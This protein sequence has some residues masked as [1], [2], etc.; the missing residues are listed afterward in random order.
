MSISGPRPSESV[1]PA[2]Q[3]MAAVHDHITPPRA[4]PPKGRA[5]TSTVESRR[6]LEMLQGI[7]G[8]TSI[9]A[10]IRRDLPRDLA[11]GA[12]F[13]LGAFGVLVGGVGAL[14]MK[15]AS[16]AAGAAAGFVGTILG[17]IGNKIFGKPQSTE[18]AMKEAGA[19]LPVRAA[20]VAFAGLPSL[21]DGAISKL[22]L[23][24]VEALRSSG[25]VSRENGALQSAE[26]FFNAQLVTLADA[27]KAAADIEGVGKKIGTDLETAAKKL[28]ERWERGSGQAGEEPEPIPTPKSVPVPLLSANFERAEAEDGAGRAAER[29]ESVSTP[30]RASKPPL[31]FPLY[32]DL[33]RRWDSILKDNAKIPLAEWQKDAE[34]IHGTPSVIALGRRNLQQAV[35]DA[36]TDRHIKS[37]DDPVRHHPVFIRQEYSQQQ[38]QQILSQSDKTWMLC[39][40]LQGLPVLYIRDPGS[41]VPVE[42]R[43][44]AGFADLQDLPPEENW[45]PTF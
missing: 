21:M 19:S 40:D 31:P 36:V 7:A 26:K 37:H 17:G 39:E 34:K 30:K 43:R 5:Q 1:G 3:P 27:K 33:K 14:A 13:A 6:Q 42:A 20:V 38:A 35:A 22:G 25:V 32:A 29:P 9:I 11:A 24:G 16:G 4:L 8:P 12:K 18:N 41:S 44:V 45:T 15:V 28:G 2:Q 23:L 10:K